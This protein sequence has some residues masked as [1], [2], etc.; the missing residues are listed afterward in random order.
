LAGA[1]SHP[2]RAGRR[3]APLCNRLRHGEDCLGKARAR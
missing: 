1:G 3:I 2:G